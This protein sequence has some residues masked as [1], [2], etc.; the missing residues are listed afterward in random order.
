MLR[1]KSQVSGA[2]AGFTLLELLVVL[3]IAGLTISVAMATS[4]SREPNLQIL[5]TQLTSEL[6]FAR[7]LA[8]SQNRPVTMVVD[9]NSRILRSTSSRTGVRLPDSI[10]MTFSPI[11]GI[12]RSSPTPRLVFFSDGSSTGGVFKLSDHSRAVVVRV[13]WL[14]GAVTRDGGR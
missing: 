6:N 14:S 9:Q 12:G 13:D 3:V 7:V 4:R 8:I 2:D 11:E 10:R 5:S 1:L